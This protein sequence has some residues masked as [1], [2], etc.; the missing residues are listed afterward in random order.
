M[1]QEAGARHVAACLVGIDAIPVEQILTCGVEPQFVGIQLRVDAHHPFQSVAR[2][3]H[4]A[5]FGEKLLVVDEPLAQVV[6]LKV[7]AHVVDVDAE[8]SGVADEPVARPVSEDAREGAEGEA[9]LLE[10]LPF[11]LVVYVARRYVAVRASI[12]VV[13]YSYAFLM[14]K[15]LQ[16]FTCMAGARKK[17]NSPSCRFVKPSGL[18]FPLCVMM[19]VSVLASLSSFILLSGSRCR[20]V[21]S[22][23]EGGVRHYCLAPAVGWHCKGSESRQKDEI[24]HS[25]PLRAGIVSAGRVGMSVF[26]G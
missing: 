18:R 23:R 12:S 22:R 3:R 7:A 24:L 4:E 17:E 5:E 13:I 20:S 8:Q 2:W 19:S 11:L 16:G 21:P 1:W 26:G 14:L 10:E 9:P 25:V 15:V 6:E